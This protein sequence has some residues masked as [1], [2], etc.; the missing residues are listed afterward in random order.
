V[1]SFYEVLTSLNGS[2]F[3]WK[4]IWRVKAPSR[5]A[6]FVW[7]ADLRKIL[8]FDNL[9]KR[10]MV[11]VEWCC[12]CNKSGE[13]ID[14]LLIHCEVARELW[15]SILNLFGVNWVIPRRMSDLLV[16]MEAR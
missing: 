10:D 11:V 3:P 15:S 2:S 16:S 5:V 9:R 14:H 12:I 4:S 1:K 7:T 13:F 6:F 8:T